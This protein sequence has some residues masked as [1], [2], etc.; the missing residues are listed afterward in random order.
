MGLPATIL[1]CRKS[2]CI[3]LFAIIN[4]A[5]STRICLPDCPPDDLVIQPSQAACRAE[6]HVATMTRGEWLG[7]IQQ[8]MRD[9]KESGDAPHAL[10]F[11]HG[12][13]VSFEEA[14]QVHGAKLVSKEEKEE[15]KEESGEKN[16]G[17]KTL[18]VSFSF[19]KK[20]F[21]TRH[22]NNYLT[23]CWRTRLVRHCL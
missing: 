21:F 13:N 19:W 9:V 2:T 8:A 6:S 4:A 10:V 14:A 7:E 1:D 3:T 22:I 16:D 15:S 18:F 17:K 11:L 12:F 23:R 20:L 5:F